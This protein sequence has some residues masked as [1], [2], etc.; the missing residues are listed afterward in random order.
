MI[1]D[2]RFMIETVEYSKCEG[3]E[4]TKN[5]KYTTLWTT[6]LCTLF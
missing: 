3:C 4:G 5:Q 2:Y 6:K 1:Y